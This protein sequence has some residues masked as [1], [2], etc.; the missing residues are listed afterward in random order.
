[1]SSTKATLPGA[2]APTVALPRPDTAETSYP[3]AFLLALV[4]LRSVLTAVI[5]SAVWFVCA[6]ILQSNT[7]CYSGSHYLP[8]AAVT[9]ALIIALAIAS[10]RPWRGRSAPLVV[11]QALATGTWTAAGVLA[12]MYFAAVTGCGG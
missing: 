7:S 8:S 2:G 9:F 1:M 5:G 6:E 10:R 3:I 12:A 11:G 4:S